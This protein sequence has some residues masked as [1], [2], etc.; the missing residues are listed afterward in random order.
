[1]ANRIGT[2]LF[3]H[4]NRITTALDPRLIPGGI[5]VW[6]SRPPDKPHHG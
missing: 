6:K 2:A 1:M 5:Q 4:W 3:P